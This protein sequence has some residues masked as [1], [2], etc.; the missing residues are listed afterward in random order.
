MD[1]VNIYNFGS[2]SNFIPIPNSESFMPFKKV[3]YN[4]LS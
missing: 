1:N 2:L 4:G 3:V